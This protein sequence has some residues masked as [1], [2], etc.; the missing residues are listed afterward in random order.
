MKR[1]FVSLALA[2]SLLSTAAYAGQPGNN[3]GGNGGCGVGQQ[4]NGC[5]TTTT[6]GTVNNG[7]QGGA[8]GHS[9]AIQ[10]QGQAQGQI[11]G[12]AQGQGQGQQQSVRNS[13]R[14]TNANVNANRN[15]NRNTNTVR[16]SNRNTNTSSSTSTSSSRSSANNNGNRQSMTY[17]ESRDRLQAPGIA[18]SFSSVS[19]NPCEGAPFG[20]GGSGPGF[21]GLL[22][23]PRESDRC[24]QERQTIL[25]H[26]M[27]YTNAAI[28]VLAGNPVGVAIQNNPYN[29]RTVRQRVIRAKN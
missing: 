18:A 22:Q 4:T 14:N 20:L 5:G 10:G 28:A 3:G 24:W 7:G 6:P 16:S 19:G 15:A 13:V 17:N 25:L 21:G 9:T 29:T 23:F 26:Q 12:Q 8:G 11:Q 1:L 2:A 27:G